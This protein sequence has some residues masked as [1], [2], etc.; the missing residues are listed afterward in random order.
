MTRSTA[1]KKALI[2]R[3]DT[4]I[5]RRLALLNDEQQLFTMRESEWQEQ[6]ADNSAAR[7]LGSLSDGELH[8][9][10]RIHA[11]LER[12]ESGVYGICVVCHKQVPAARLRAVPEAD[13]CTTC[14]NS[15]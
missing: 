7:V 11:A 15:H 14:R 6:A 9:L 2:T 4:L 1:A 13:R 8:E 10:Q 3:R 5:Q 12:I